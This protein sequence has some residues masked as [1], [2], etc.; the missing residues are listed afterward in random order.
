MN[1]VALYTRFEATFESARYYENPV[2]DVSVEAEFECA[3]VRRTTHAFW[4]G[5]RRWRV[6]FSPEMPGRWTWSVRCS[7]DGDS[8]FDGMGGTFECAPAPSTNALYQRG[9]IRVSDD[10]RHFVSADGTPFFWLGDTAWN[11]P[12]KSSEADWTEYLSDRAQKGFNVIQFVSTQWIS[13]AGDGEGRPAYLGRERI[14]IEPAFFRR[15]D[16]RVNAINAFGMVAAPVLAWA[17]GW[18]PDSCHLNPGNSLSDEQLELLIRYIVA[19]YN[20]HYVVWILAGDGIYEGV[21]AERWRRIGRAVFSGN[22]RPATM[23]PGG[24]IW[25]APEFRTE[26]WFHFNGYQSGHWNDDDNFRWINEGP[27]S[28]D[29]RTEPHCPHINLEPC[30]EGHRAM[31]SGR[32]MDAGDVRRAAYWSLL[33]APPA[34]ITYGAHGIWSWESTPELPMSHPNTGIAPAWRDA[35]H[36]PGSACMGRL[37]A[38]FESID[39]PSLEPYP[40]LVELQP[41]TERPALFIAAARSRAGDLAVLY[42]PRG[43]TVQLRTQLMRPDM[44]VSCVDPS[45]GCLLW[46]RPLAECGNAIDSGTAADR[47][48]VF[49]G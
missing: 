26:P 40:E 18:N 42:L 38:I 1:T 23:H 33:A 12:L 11:G 32:A 8:G 14:R 27:P 48:L 2:H 29:W 4:D 25:S 16:R 9:P 45:N 46:R 21:E 7:P 19:R 17:A 34:G 31:S 41:G 10:K 49:R 44:M 35:L 15:L 22:A 28:V 43:G 24:K 37:K 13:A 6:R 30:Y 3:G 39:W 5:E 36:L 20:A 47:V